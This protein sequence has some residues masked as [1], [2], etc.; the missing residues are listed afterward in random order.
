M[1]EN[2][3]WVNAVT[4]TKRGLANGAVRQAPRTRTA[5]VSNRDSVKA[6][7]RIRPD[8]VYIVYGFGHTVPQP[9][10]LA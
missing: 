2:E 6:T 5:S 7:Q 1:P 9:K 4:A 10:R 3:V 8:C